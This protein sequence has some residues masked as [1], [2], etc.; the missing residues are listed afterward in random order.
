VRAP[1]PATSQLMPKEFFFRAA[2]GFNQRRARDPL[3]KLRVRQYKIIS[4]MST[5]H[6]A[7]CLL[8]PSAV[9]SC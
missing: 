8:P 9:P 1:I 6:R 7:H 3:F 4:A 2:F 5:L